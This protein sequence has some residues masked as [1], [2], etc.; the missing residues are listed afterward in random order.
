M[1]RFCLFVK[2]A[3]IFLLC[4]LPALAQ[5]Q[6]STGAITGRV[7]DG[8]GAALPG[9]AVVVSN[10]AQAFERSIVTGPEG[11]F[12]APEG[13]AAWEAVKKLVTQGKV[14]RGERIVVFDTGT[15]YKYVE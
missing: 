4:A 11:L 7:L 10:P 6:A 15:G 9:A 14:D 12:A 1:T 13:G 3:A 5:S 2:G 8:T